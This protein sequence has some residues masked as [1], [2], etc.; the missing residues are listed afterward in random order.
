VFG[1]SKRT[2]SND[3]GELETHGLLVVEGAG[4]ATRYRLA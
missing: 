2:A 3:L 4:R 1:A